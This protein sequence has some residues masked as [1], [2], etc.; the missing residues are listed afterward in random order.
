MTDRLDD[1]RIEL[2]FRNRDGRFLSDPPDEC[3]RSWS[4]RTP[5]CDFQERAAPS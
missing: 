2:Q 1:A 5:M 4:V 3:V